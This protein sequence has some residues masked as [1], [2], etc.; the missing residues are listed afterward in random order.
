MTRAWRLRPSALM[1]RAQVSL[2]D[3]QDNQLGVLGAP[4]LPEQSR[5]LDPLGFNAVRRVPIV[6][7]TPGNLPAKR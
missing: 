1:Y 5:D 4:S 6:D 2:R 7:P 3:A